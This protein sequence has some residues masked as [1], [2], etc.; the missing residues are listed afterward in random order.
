MELGII[1]QNEGK[2]FEQDFSNSINK[3]ECWL[4]RLRDN[5]ASFGGGVNIRFASSNI[6]DYIMFHNKTKT[7]YLLELKSTKSS[8]I[9]YAMI[10]DN[11]IKEL[12]ESSK[13]N[14]VSGFIFNYRE[15]NNATYFMYIQDF[16]NMT[17]NITK[18]S[19]NIDDLTKY[20][21]IEIDCEKKRTRYR[22]GVCKF[23]NDTHL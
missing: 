7:L 18:K 19:F 13:H 22:Y 1:A 10:R 11:Q 6:C 23:V 9:P 3:D 15:K 12:T 20:G 8:S 4:Y 14:I 21:A 2:K 5:A 16:N 17:S